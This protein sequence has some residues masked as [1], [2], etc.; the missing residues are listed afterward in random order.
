[1]DIG[2][3]RSSKNSVFQE[4]RRDFPHHRLLDVPSKEQSPDRHLASQGF[5]NSALFVLAI[6]LAA[7]RR[8]R[9]GANHGDYGGNTGCDDK[10]REAHH[11]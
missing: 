1:M 8:S 6:G 10:G 2:G 9:R 5:G 7:A 3:N 11:E 4:L